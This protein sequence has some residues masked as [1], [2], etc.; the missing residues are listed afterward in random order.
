MK[1]NK[2][3]QLVKQKAAPHRGHVP[4]GKHSSKLNL[5]NP[6]GVSRNRTLQIRL[7]RQI[8][9]ILP[10]YIYKN[11]KMNN[12]K[13]IKKKKKKMNIQKLPHN[14]QVGDHDAI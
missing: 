8:S 9:A 11:Q 7:T 4:N 2:N 13:K 1:Q 6:I 10:T 12:L 3:N 14:H 5:R